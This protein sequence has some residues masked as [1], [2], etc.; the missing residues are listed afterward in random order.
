MTQID[1]AYLV[2]DLESSQQ[3]EVFELLAKYPEL[4]EPFAIAVGEK[5][6]ALKDGDPL[7]VQKICEDEVA[8]LKKII[9]TL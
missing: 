8:A 9:E 5:I 4:Y 2:R 6:S 1:L 7:K 3:L